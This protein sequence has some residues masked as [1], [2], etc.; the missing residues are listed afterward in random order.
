MI[1]ITYHF[2]TR[3]HPFSKNVSKMANGRNVKSLKM[4]QK[5]NKILSFGFLSFL[6][7]HLTIMRHLRTAL[8]KQGDFIFRTLTLCQITAWVCLHSI[9]SSKLLLMMCFEKCEVIHLREVDTGSE[10]VNTT[11][12]S[13]QCACTSFVSVVSVLMWQWHTEIEW[14]RRIIS[15]CRSVSMLPRR[16]FLSSN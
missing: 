11:V 14:V 13:S 7:R 1:Q 9:K 15:T 4:S 10:A 16:C 12:H 5:L 2:P 6:M 3:V 8:E